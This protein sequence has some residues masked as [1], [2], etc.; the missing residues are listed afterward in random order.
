MVPPGNSMGSGYAEARSLLVDHA[1]LASL[2]DE[3]GRSAMKAQHS[4]LAAAF[5]VAAARC[6]AAADHLDRERHR[7]HGK[8]YLAVLR[9]RL[10]AD[11][12][13]A[14]RRRRNIAAEASP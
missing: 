3:A 9:D 6:A 14:A 4:M 8:D 2:V 7:L 12:V 1:E 13:E 11:E 5:S 10:T